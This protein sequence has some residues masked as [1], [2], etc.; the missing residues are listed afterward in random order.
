M[1]FKC[2]TQFTCSMPWLVVALSETVR[3]KHLMHF[4]VAEPLTF[5]ITNG[6]VSKCGIA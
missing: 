2:G 6:Q 1:D 5:T 3:M 4:H